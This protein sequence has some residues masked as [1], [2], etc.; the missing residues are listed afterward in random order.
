[1][2]SLDLVVVVCEPSLVLSFSPN[3][4][5]GIDIEYYQGK[6]KSHIQ[7][8][9]QGVSQCHKRQAALINDSPS[10]TGFLVTF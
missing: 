10:I 8:F 2:F 6:Q 1:M 4:A 9:F 5:F 3:K 7:I